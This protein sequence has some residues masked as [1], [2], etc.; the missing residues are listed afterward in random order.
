MS[1]PD[2]D[3]GKTGLY[4]FKIILTKTSSQMTRAIVNE[5]IKYLTRRT[6]LSAGQLKLTR[7]GIQ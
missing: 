4:H 5:K 6:F 3:L 1:D 2:P 7:S